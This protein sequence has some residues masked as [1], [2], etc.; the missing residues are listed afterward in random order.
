MRLL[1]LINAPTKLYISGEARKNCRLLYGDDLASLMLESIKNVEPQA[2]PKP[3]KNFMEKLLNKIRPKKE[4]SIGVFS[5]RD[6]DFFVQSNLKVG[7][8]NF[9]SAPHRFN[10][11]ETL[12]SLK[13]FREVIKQTHDDILKEIETFNKNKRLFKF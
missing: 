3:P 13:S 5:N 2:A 11:L 9:L 12:E 6:G 10:F 8:F 1:K 4:M 7:N